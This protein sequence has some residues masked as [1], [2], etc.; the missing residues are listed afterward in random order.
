M[1]CLRSALVVGGFLALILAT[2]ADAQGAQRHKQRPGIDGL[3][4]PLIAAEV[5]EK[6]KLTSEQKEKVSKIEAEFAAK[7]KDTETK[8]REL[9]QKAR[10]DKDRAAYQKVKEQTEE[11]TRTRE[12]YRAKV[13]AL[14][15]AEQKKTLDE[16]KSDGGRPSRPAARPADSQSSF[17]PPAVRERL[18][19]TPEQIQKLNQ[20]QKDFESKSLQVLTEEQRKQYEQFRS[21]TRRPERRRQRQTSAVLRLEAGLC[22]SKDSMVWSGT[23]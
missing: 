5:Q 9:A 19:L 13:A 2:G 18:N 8:I 12:A 3:G 21:R 20:L 10:Q 1:W 15:N 17:L 11:A 4:G 6:L 22:A 16:A 23:C 14:L 7:V